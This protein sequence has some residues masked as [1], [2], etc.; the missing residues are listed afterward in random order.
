MKRF[1]LPSKSSHEKQSTGQTPSSHLAGYEEIQNDGSRSCGTKW[2]LLEN[3]PIQSGGGIAPDG[4]I[5]P[6]SLHGERQNKRWLN[7]NFGPAWL[8]EIEREWP[9]PPEN[10]SN[11]TQNEIEEEETKKTTNVSLAAV[12]TTQTIEWHLDRISTW[13][14]LRS[15][16]AWILRVMANK[17]ENTQSW[18]RP[19]RSNKKAD[20]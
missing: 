15:R 3:F 20:K 7:Q 18:N 5:H 10:N 6:I 16:T 12:E 19:K 13:G 11:E 4:R 9:N 2:N 8:T 1:E 14:E 17:E